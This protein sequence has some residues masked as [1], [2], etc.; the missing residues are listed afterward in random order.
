MKIYMTKIP[1]GHI[2]EIMKFALNVFLLALLHSCASGPLNEAQKAEV[3]DVAVVSFLEDRMPI[4][5]LGSTIFQNEKTDVDVPQWSINQTLKDAIAKET[6]KNGRVYRE[7]K[8]DKLKAR[9]ALKESDTTR[10]RLLNMQEKE[11]NQ[12][13]FTTAREKGAKFLWIIKPAAHP[14]Y[15]EQTGFGLF[16]RAPLGSAGEWHSY[17]SFQAALWDVTTAKKVFQGGINP[18]LMKTLSG[19]VC[20]EIKKYSAKR[21]AELFKSSFTKMLQD[22]A[23]LLNQWSGLSPKPLN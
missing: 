18:E 14:Y 7:I 4:T 19:K 8:F 6:K 17:L 5:Y 1:P 22:S 12:L 10:N 11:M 23:V 16:C 3:N 9:A 21:F 13:L 2:L 15:P 20:R